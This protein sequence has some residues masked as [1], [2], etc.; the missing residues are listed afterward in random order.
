MSPKRLVIVG[1]VAGGMSCAARARRLSEDAEII[2]LEQGREVSFANCGLPYYV[3]GEIADPSSLLLHTPQSLNKIFNIDVH[4]GT[5]V[6]GIDFESKTLKVESADGEEDELTYDSL[7]LSPGGKPLPILDEKALHS[8]RVHTLRTVEDA[9]ALRELALS[10]QSAVV[11]GGGFIGIEA[12]EAFVLRGLDTHVIELSDHIL[13]PLEREMAQLVNDHL[14]SR[15]LHIHTQTSA[16]HVEDDGTQIHV[17]LSDGSTLVADVLV[18]STGVTPNTE[19]FSKAGLEVNE[20]GAVITDEHG[21]TNQPGVYAVGDA[22][23]STLSATGK[24]A[25]V[26]LAGPANRAGRLIADHIF[27]PET[28]RPLPALLSTAIVRAGSLTAGMTGANRKQLDADGI[29]YTTIHLHPNQHAVYFPGASPV[30]LM[31]HF[32]RQTGRILGAQGVGEHGVDKRIDVIATAMHANMPINELIDIDFAY[33]PPYGAAKDPINMVGMVGA[34][35]LDGQ[36][37]VIESAE[38]IDLPEDWVVLDVRSRGEFASGHLPGAINIPHTELRK[39]AEE[40]REAAAG[41]KLAVMCAAGVRSWI[42]YRIVKAQGYEAKM[43]SGGIQT[44]RAW[45]GK[46]ADQVLVTESCG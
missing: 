9:L 44:L 33:A 30:H 32:D 39:R 37:E 1:G 10:G 29:E 35:V 19:V 42:G 6:V 12:A 26:A 46:S 17:K 23:L 15:G 21:R 28:A 38:I 5:S 11:I 27:T 7:V 40:L 8:P 43:L 25:V 16:E 41:R 36:L 24:Q 45:L 4:T 31:V 13:P 2:V 18:L 34:N 3:G 20:R 22:V 14:E